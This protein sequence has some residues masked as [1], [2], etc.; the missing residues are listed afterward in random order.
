MQRYIPRKVN[1]ELNVGPDLICH[2]FSKQE[3]LDSFPMH[4]I[5]SQVQPIKKKHLSIASRPWFWLPEWLPGIAPA[6]RLRK[7]WNS[8]AENGTSPL[9]AQWLDQWTQRWKARTKSQPKRLKGS[10]LCHRWATCPGVSCGSTSFWLLTWATL[11]WVLGFGAWAW[12]IYFNVSGSLPCLI[13]QLETQMTM[14]KS[15]NN[16][17][18]HQNLKMWEEQQVN[19]SNLNSEEHISTWI[20]GITFRSS[21]WCVCHALEL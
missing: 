6:F 4:A 19:S 20:D 21:A 2:K 1:F 17:H 5:D 8:F 7:G 18:V 15:I 9:P 14:E 3:T 13:V 11:P 10:T 12:R 16:I